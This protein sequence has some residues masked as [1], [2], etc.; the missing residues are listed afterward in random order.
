[1]FLNKKKFFVFVMKKNFEIMIKSYGK[2]FNLFVV[3]DACFHAQ[4]KTRDFTVFMNTMYLY[5][6]L[7]TVTTFKISPLT[8]LFSFC[9]ICKILSI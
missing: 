9:C 3:C 8:Y 5:R 6:I 4:D 7:M 2:L 1:M